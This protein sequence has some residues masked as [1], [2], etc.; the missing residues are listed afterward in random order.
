ML[1]LV[2][3]VTILIACG[4]T[5]TGPDSPKRNSYLAHSGKIF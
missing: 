3:T 1:I 5:T 4:K 2:I